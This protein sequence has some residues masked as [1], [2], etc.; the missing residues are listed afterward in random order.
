MIALGGYHEM[1]T[2]SKSLATLKLISSG[3][4]Q[5]INT[6][7]IRRLESRFHRN[8]MIEALVGFALIASVAVL[9]DSGLPATEYQNQLQQISP[10]SA[11]AVT[12]NKNTYTET[13]YGQ[14]G[15]RVVLTIDPYYSG[16]NNLSISFLDSKGSLIPMQSARLTYTQVDKGIG[17]I[18]E[19]IQ[20]TPQGLFA[21]STNTFAIAGHWNLQVEGVQNAANSL[22]IIGT[23]KDLYLSPKID[24]ISAS[25]KQYIIAQNDSRP[26]F[27]VY[28]KIRNTVWIGDAMVDSH[29]IYSFDLGSKAFV[30]H[31][32]Q[33]VSDVTYMGLNN[34]DGTLWYIDPLTKLLGNY[35]PDTG[36]NQIYK[37]PA[38]TGGILAGLAIDP[39]GNVWISI[40]NLSGINQ[41]LKFDPSKAAFDTI[42]L[43][44]NSQPQELAIDDMTGYVWV[45]ESGTGKIAEIDPSDNNSVRE[46]PAGNGTLDTPTAILIDPLT[47]KIFV[48]EHEGQA[49]SS[50]DP[51]LKTFTRYA[52]NKDPNNLPFDMT[53]DNNHN[54]WVAEHTLDKIS[55]INPRT[56]EV[57]EFVIPSNESLTQHITTDS[58]G[59]VILVEQGSHSLG[60]LTTS[61]GLSPVISAGASLPF[62]YPGIGLGI[63]AGPSIAIAIVALSFFYIKSAKDM[64]ETG[65][66]ISK[67]ADR[68]KNSAP[69]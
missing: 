53:F 18:V 41:I 44:P 24:T 34:M 4:M 46:Y 31:D 69:I 10:S 8:I 21:S 58:Q 64:N 55:V 60:L 22:N 38:P 61:A 27:P 15:T 47:G 37:V 33:G 51:I 42:T 63:I 6:D 45:A 9:V 40:S 19:N 25:I 36:K 49:V 26:L 57:S 5:S 13:A 67:L 56:S 28:D 23:F 59:D 43:P 2:R 66:L 16:S 50:F 65:W 35:N 3:G 11:F 32:L 14:N 12:E 17:P 7:E 39:N 62:A 68:K 20:P 29:R 30:E 48:S 1:A 54:L 52:L